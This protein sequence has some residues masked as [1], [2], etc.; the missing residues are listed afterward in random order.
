MA[1]R[2]AG[3]II[4]SPSIFGQCH[5]AKAR[6]RSTACGRGAYAGRTCSRGV[7]MAPWEDRLLLGGID[8]SL[9]MCRRHVRAG[10][11]VN[12][13]ANVRILQS[14]E[15][16]RNTDNELSVPPR[17]ERTKTQAEC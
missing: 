3:R 5:S 14:L 17:E 12:L 8:N 15:L 16:L 10:S 4:A 2:C 9:S 6:V 13:P 7:S 1:P 11:G